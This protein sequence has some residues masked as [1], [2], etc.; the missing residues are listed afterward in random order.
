MTVYQPGQR[1][2]LVHTSDPHTNLRPGDLGTVHRHHQGIGTVDV[3][4]DSGSRLSML[5]DDGDR[6]APVN[7]TAGTQPDAPKP[8]TTA[9]QG[10]GA[11]E[12]QDALLATAT[13]AGAAAGRAAADWWAQHT[14]GGRSHGDVRAAARRI[15]TGI[16]DG[17]PA[18]SDTLPVCDR[19]DDSN[20][21]LDEELHPHDAA[22]VLVQPL[23][24]AERTAALDAYADAYDQAAETRVVE[25]CHLAASPTGTDLSHLHPDRVG[26]GSAGVFSGD[27]YLTPTV[28][29]DRYSTG[30]VGTL[31]RRWNGWAVFTC[32][33]QVADAIVAEHER[34]RR[35]RHDALR[36]TDVEAAE[37]DTGVDSCLPRLFFDGDVFV[38]DLRA[39]QDDPEAIERVPPDRYGGYVVMGGIWCWDAVDPNACDRIIGDIPEPDGEREVRL[40]H[41]PQ[42]RVP[43]DRLRLTGVQQWPT[44]DELA[45]TGDLTL[46]GVHV[47][48]VTQGAADSAADRYT[49]NLVRD[50]RDIRTYLSRCRLDDGAPVSMQRLLHAI[51]DEYY[52]DAAITQAG[53][54]GGTQVRLV[55]DAGHTRALRPLLDAPRDYTELLH[56]ARELVADLWPAPAGERWQVW[57][58]TCWTTLHPTRPA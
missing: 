24:A 42:L 16:D 41:T 6:I 19:S 44:G 48:T 30:Y 9:A 15:L 11:P 2:R 57:T 49:L 14:I 12:R 31:L 55:D 21:D 43:H 13:A 17:D 39:M 3:E 54:E 53:R 32:T 38:A 26:I 25:L 7:D 20:L 40:R 33:R 35:E 36:E 18:V 1:I 8:T 27:W 51:A 29:G 23:T 28:D 37:I 10:E 58:G 46:D 34:Q 47:G 22:T 4:W 45:F 5:L 52:L 56:C 50:R